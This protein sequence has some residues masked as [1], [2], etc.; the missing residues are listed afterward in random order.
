MH[1]NVLQYEPEIALFVPNN[2]PLK[3]YE[4]IAD[5]SIKNLT[6]GGRLYFEI[7]EDF[8][9]QILKMLNSKGYYKIELRK[10]LQGKDRMVRAFLK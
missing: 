7:H 2:H 8:G 6:H 3:F 1:D 10:D 4:A 9:D 5:F